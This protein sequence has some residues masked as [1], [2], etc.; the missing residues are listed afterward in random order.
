[1]RFVLRKTIIP[2]WLIIGLGLEACATQE[3]IRAELT[4][5][6]HRALIKEIVQE[7][8]EEKM[9]S[10]EHKMMMKKMMKETMEKKMK[11]K[12]QKMMMKKETT[13]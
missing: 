4:S 12:E 8:M 7:T 6:E 13:N 10:K 5:E 3:Q 9:K 11:S 2:L 1:M